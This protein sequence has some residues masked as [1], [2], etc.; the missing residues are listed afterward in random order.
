MLAF[1]D[2]L[3]S[4]LKIVPLISLKNHWVSLKIDKFK[5][6]QDTRT[7][8]SPLRLQQMAYGRMLVLSSQ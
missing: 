8:S 1:D 2:A 6:N 5:L 4:S 7:I 3:W